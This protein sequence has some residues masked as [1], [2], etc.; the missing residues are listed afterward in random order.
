[1]WY[2]YAGDNDGVELVGYECIW[3]KYA[4]DKFLRS[5]MS[6]EVYDVLGMRCAGTVHEE[7]S[8]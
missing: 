2:K 3:Y 4:G 5:V 1:M 8:L 7:V 6:C